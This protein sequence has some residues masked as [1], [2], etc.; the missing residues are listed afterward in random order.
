VPQR[1][2]AVSSKSTGRLA[3]LGVEEG[4][5]V[6]KGQVMAT[7]ENEDLVAQRNQAA[8]Q[9]KDAQAAAPKPSSPTPGCSMNASRRW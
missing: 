6:K 4:S 3:Y 1:Q 9:I 2:A 5:K 7:L 8:A